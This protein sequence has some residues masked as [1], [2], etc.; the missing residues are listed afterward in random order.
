MKKKTE[1]SAV[2]TSTIISK[3]GILNVHPVWTELYVPYIKIEEDTFKVIK[4]VIEAIEA[5]ETENGM[6]QIYYKVK[7]EAWE[8]MSINILSNAS[9]SYDQTKET[10]NSFLNEQL[11][12][13]NEYVN[14][15]DETK[16]K[17]NKYIEMFTK[18]IL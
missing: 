15:L 11:T 18:A 5:L 6:L 10:I 9:T 8:L 7:D 3:E 16:Q 1:E 12:Q 14:K 13:L 4:V 17:Q 2:P